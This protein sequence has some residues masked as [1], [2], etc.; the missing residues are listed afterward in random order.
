MV[1]I[2]SVMV[3]MSCAVS[4]INSQYMGAQTNNSNR[5]HLTLNNGLGG[6]VP[7]GDILLLHTSIKVVYLRDIPDS[8]GLLVWTLGE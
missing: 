1:L 8:G 6:M 3:Y 5:C 2:F 4:V 7:T